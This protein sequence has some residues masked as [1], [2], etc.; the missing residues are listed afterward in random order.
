VHRRS[1]WCVEWIYSGR[2]VFFPFHIRC[3]W[4]ILKLLKLPAI[5][6]AGTQ[7]CMAH[8]EGEI[9]K[10]MVHDTWKQEMGCE[11]LVS[12]PSSSSFLEI[13]SVLS[14]SE[15]WHWLERTLLFLA[16]YFHSSYKF[17]IE[18]GNALFFW[19]YPNRTCT[20]FYFR[21]LDFFFFIRKFFVWN[22]VYFF[23]ILVDITTILIK[24]LYNSS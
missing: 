23:T 24:V 14:W 1:R 4:K 18:V 15:T 17:T 5:K 20:S 22:P 13:F 3:T 6:M 9:E 2:S 21:L 10:C 12:W 7:H 11:L 8:S 16:F 19:K